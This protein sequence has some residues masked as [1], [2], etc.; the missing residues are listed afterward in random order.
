M[1]DR[2]EKMKKALIS[3]LLV[4]ALAFSFCACA[5][6]KEVVKT[7]QSSADFAE[8]GLA[9]EAPEGAQNQTYSVVKSSHNG[10]ELDIAQIR[11]EYDGISCELRTANIGSYN[12]SGFDESKA[13]SE[14]AYD[15]NVGDYSSQ[16]RVMRVNSMYVAIW[17]LGEHSYSL[18][19][20]TDDSLTVTSCA[21]D[22]A[23]ANVPAAAQVT[24]EA[25]SE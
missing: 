3:M 14:E 5:G 1:L 17:F 7:Y 24:T 23:N 15:L 9:L 19:A 25:V 11:Y 12:V 21:I 22:A 2:C 6:K 18:S 20:K 13:S 8:L 10:E 4:L 16:I